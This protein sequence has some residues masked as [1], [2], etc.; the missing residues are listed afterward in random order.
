LNLLC[1]RLAPAFIRSRISSAV[2]IPPTPINGICPRQ[3]KRKID[4][5]IIESK[6]KNHLEYTIEIVE[7]FAMLF[8]SMVF[9]LVHQFHFDVHFLEYP[10]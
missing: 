9:H 1:T 7:E 6:K 3:K 4:F 10:F 8:L 2:S 5:E